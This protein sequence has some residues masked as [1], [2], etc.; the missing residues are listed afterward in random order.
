MLQSVFQLGIT[1][2]YGL[3]NLVE[4][5]PSFR[6]YLFDPHHKAQ[7]VQRLGVRVNFLTELLSALAQVVHDVGGSHEHQQVEDEHE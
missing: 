1:V 4:F 7:I 5:L 6:L 3:A 2:D